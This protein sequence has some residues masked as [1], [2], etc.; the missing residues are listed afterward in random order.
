MMMIGSEHAGVRVC[1]RAPPPLLHAP[2]QVII[3]YPVKQIILYPGQRPRQRLSVL[4]PQRGAGPPVRGAVQDQ[5]SG[6]GGL[7]GGQ[8]DDDDDDDDNDG[9]AGGQ[10][11]LQRGV[12][13]GVPGEAQADEAEVR[14]EEDQQ[15]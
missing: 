4:Q 15:A 1:A 2:G 5:A 6:R 7:R 3:L 11:G 13:R 9:N 8:A 12:R 10:A 14:P